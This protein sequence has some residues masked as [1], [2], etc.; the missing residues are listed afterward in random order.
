MLDQ[1]TADRRR[2]L[3]GAVTLA[4]GLLTAPGPVVRAAEPAADGVRAI[5]SR[6]ELFVD[7]FLVDRLDNAVLQLHSPQLAPAMTEPANS[8]EYGTII[9]DGDIYRLYTRDHRN[10]KFDGD[11][12]EVTRYCESRDG[13]HW[14]RPNLGLVEVDGTRENNVILH[15]PPFCHNFCP[16][17]DRR[18]GVPAEERFKA[19]A[20]TV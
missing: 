8:L 9:L 15:Q 16:M 12:T 4:G 19:L 17:L 10:S 3:Q 13:I 18:P 7:R 2:F 20:G 1:P 6:R 14:T 5:G 11:V